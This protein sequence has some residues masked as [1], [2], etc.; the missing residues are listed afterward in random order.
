MRLGTD[1][2]GPE[3]GKVMNAEGVG[4]RRACRQGAGLA[5][6]YGAQGPEELPEESPVHATTLDPGWGPVLSS[7]AR[8]STLLPGNPKELRVRCR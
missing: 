3:L 5:L 4:S 6:Q 2:G 1:T 7:R 8:K